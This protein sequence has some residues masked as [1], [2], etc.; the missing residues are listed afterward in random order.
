[1]NFLKIYFWQIVSIIFNFATVFVVTP[2]LSSNPAIFGIYS[3]VTAAYIFLSYADLGFLS[4]GMKYAS[5]CFARNERKEEIMIIGFAGF[6]FLIFV[7]LFYY[8]Y[9]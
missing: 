6:I 2:F 8:D 3:I 5:E 4:A 1:M 7:I 9:T